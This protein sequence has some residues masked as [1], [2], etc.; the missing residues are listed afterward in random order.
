MLDFHKKNTRKILSC[1]EPTDSYEL[2]YKSP[3]QLIEKLKHC[4]SS[5]QKK[6]KLKIRSKNLKIVIL[7]LPQYYYNL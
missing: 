1:R 2:S 6:K 3:Q 5:N 7:L 4:Q